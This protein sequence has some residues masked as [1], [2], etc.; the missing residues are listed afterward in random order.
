M[1]NLENIIEALIFW[2][3]E[4]VTISWLQK[5]LKVE[6]GQV[7]EALRAIEARLCKGIVLIRNGEEV[8]L[9]TSPEA[10]KIIEEQRKE[11]LSRELSKSALET[12]S[13]ILYKGPVK[14]SEIDYIR[15]VNSQFI[16]RHLETR[17]LI[18]KK[19]S[20]DDQRSYEYSVSFDLLSH[21][22]IKNINELPEY[23]VLREKIELFEENQK[24]EISENLQDEE[25]GNNNDNLN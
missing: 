3:N 19:N 14:R 25:V 23:D 16:L 15:G 13:I 11:E 10:T 7:E 1:E 20:P 9:G 12:L 17:G 22:G 21:L 6:K 5:T 2:K 18:E 8:M 4:P 24:E